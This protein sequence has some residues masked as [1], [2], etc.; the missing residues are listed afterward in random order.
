M[1]QDFKAD[2]GRF[3][4]ESSPEFLL[5]MERQLAH[6][7]E[8]KIG[9]PF[10]PEYHWLTKWDEGDVIELKSQGPISWMEFSLIWCTLGTWARLAWYL[11]NSE[12]PVP[13]SSPPPVGIRFWWD[14]L[15]AE[16]LKE[17]WTWWNTPSPNPLA[18]RFAFPLEWKVKVGLD[19]RIHLQAPPGHGD[20]LPQILADRQMV[21]NDESNNDRFTGIIHS[22]GETIEDPAGTYTWTMD[23]G[24][25][26]H[27][28]LAYL[29]E[30]LEFVPELVVV[31]M[32]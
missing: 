20:T 11:P 32:V 31:E 23:A 29:L 25:A 21:Y 19:W 2:I 10:L 28:G 3:L 8:Q 6:D 15:D 4:Q 26:G 18:G 17:R 5:E 12:A 27:E 16:A 7:F 1:A 22:L 13:P 30:G 14:V 9:A 24:S